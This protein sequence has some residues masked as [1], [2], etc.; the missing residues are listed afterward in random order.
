MNFRLLDV[1]SSFDLA[2]VR[3]RV[4]SGRASKQVDP[5][6]MDADGCYGWNSSMVQDWCSKNGRAYGCKRAGRMPEEVRRFQCRECSNHL[7]HRV[8]ASKMKEFR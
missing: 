8:V 4:Y 1:S 5:D 2:P 3:P 6:C 7:V